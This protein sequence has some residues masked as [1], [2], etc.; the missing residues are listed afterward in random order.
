MRKKI[1]VV[2]L[3]ILIFGFFPLN[4]KGESNDGITAEEQRLIQPLQKTKKSELF[5]EREATKAAFQAKREEFKIRLQTIKDQRKKLLVERIDAK[6][7]E[8]NKNHTAKYTETLNRLQTFLDKFN[9]SATEAGKLSDV[10]ANITAAQ[11]AI[12]TARKAV[13]AQAAET[14][15]MAITDDSTL[16]LNAGK[17]MSQFRHDLVAVHK[18][19]IDAKQAVQKLN[20]DRKLIKKE[21]EA[22]ESAE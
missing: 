11:T 18:L 8:V 12:D 2:V 1:I 15:T 6:I 3:L 19:V 21:K 13:D 5:Q 14:Y 17:T 10:L 4:V 9:N 20:T 16:K 22:T 7:A